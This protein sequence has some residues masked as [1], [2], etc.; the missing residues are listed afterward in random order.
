MQI[1][2]PLKPTTALLLIIDAPSQAGVVQ[3]RIPACRQK[4]TIKRPAS[5][6]TQNFTEFFSEF[7]KIWH[8]T[9]LGKI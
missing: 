8:L 5:P 2:G 6:T 4:G 3:G 9:K 7:S 1:K